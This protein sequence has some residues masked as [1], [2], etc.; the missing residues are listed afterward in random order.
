MAVVIP[1]GYAQ[2]YKSIEITN[3]EPVDILPIIGQIDTGDTWAYEHIKHLRVAEATRIRDMM[4]EYGAGNHSAEEYKQLMARLNTGMSLEHP[5]WYNNYEVIWKQPSTEWD[6]H[7]HNERDILNTLVKHANFKVIHCANW[8]DVL[9]EFL[10]NNPNSINVFWNSTYT[11][12]GNKNEYD[13]TLNK[14]NIKDLCN[15]KNFIIFV[16]GTNIKSTEWQLKN[17]IYNGEYEADENWLYSLASLSNSNK[18]TDPNTHLLVTIATDRDWI[19]DQTNETVSSSKFPVW[20]A[21]NVLF[22]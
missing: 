7:A 5:E 14:K 10:N 2:D 15:S 1:A 16:A 20:F 6:K 11:I 22:S 9:M 21:D 18:N 19:I 12:A 13:I 17:K 3:I 4:W 8:D